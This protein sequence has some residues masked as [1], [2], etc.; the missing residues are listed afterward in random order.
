MGDATFAR[1]FDAQY[2]AFGEDLIL[3]FHL[4][5]ENGGPIIELGCGTGRV[6][7]ALIQAGHHVIGIDHD[8]HMLARAQIQLAPFFP[9]NSCLVQADLQ[10][11][12]F[13]LRFKIAIASMNTLSTFDD[14]GLNAAFDNVARQLAPDGLFAFEIP[15]PAVDPFKGVDPNEPLTGFVEPE[16]GN[17]CQVYAQRIE[18]STQNH[19]EI[20]WHY[21][22][23]LTDGSTQRY[24]LR[25]KYFLRSEEKIREFLNRANCTVIEVYGDY[26]RSSFEEDSETMIVIAKANLP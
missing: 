20:L 5:A 21:D 17:P 13:D 8:R 18:G 9:Q 3:W 10:T 19:V 4:S 26:A 7:R 22:E 16:S 15:N 1:Y 6:V 11:F 12:G 23:L 24:S 14:A 25:Q 2:R